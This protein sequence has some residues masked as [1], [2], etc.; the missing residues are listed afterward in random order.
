MCEVRW[1]QLNPMC[2]LRL[3]CFCGLVSE[4]ERKCVMVCVGG[5][6]VSNMCLR[7]CLC[8]CVCY[9]MASEKSHCALWAEGFC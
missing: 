7:V 3:T 5:F 2:S 8:V 1:F 4:F 6:S 9:S